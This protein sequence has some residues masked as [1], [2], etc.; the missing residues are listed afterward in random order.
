MRPLVLWAQHLPQ[1][2]GC[3]L[4]GYLGRRGAIELAAWAGHDNDWW[5]S[6]IMP[7]A[8][9]C[10]LAA[11]VGMFLVLRPALPVLANYS[12][13]SARQINIFANI[14]VP[15]FAIYLAW[16]L[17]R[18]DWLAVEARAGLP[19][20]HGDD[21]GDTDRDTSGVAADRYELRGADRCGLCRPL[22]AGLAQGTPT[23]RLVSSTTISSLPAWM[24]SSAV[25]TTL[26]RCPAAPGIVAADGPDGANDQCHGSCDPHCGSVSRSPGLG[27]LC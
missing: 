15:F 18:E 1:L 6:L 8:G 20:R 21:V 13:R 25:A 17:F 5:A 3:Y 24:P 16:Q 27:R 14:I 23:R 7:L 22:R 10:R 2:A 9:L 12:P 19:D 11:F 4:L 26:H